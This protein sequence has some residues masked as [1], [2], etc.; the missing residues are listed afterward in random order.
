MAYAHGRLFVPVVDLCFDES[1]YGTGGLD[2]YAKDYSKGTGA[3]VAL[4]AR[5]GG[6]LWRRSFPSPD[7]GC[8]T[9]RGDVVFTA[10]Y[11]GE[12]YGLATADGAT[13]LRARARAGINGCPA[14][15]GD[16][17]LVGAGTDHPAFPRPVFE[18]IAYAL[19]AR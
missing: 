5:T 13:V 18:L 19:P 11:D 4:D 7:F 10:T 9:V 15:A 6:R 1:A 8:A 17:L 16:T 14:V 3:L 2:F 12:I